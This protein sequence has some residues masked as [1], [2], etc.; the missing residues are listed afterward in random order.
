MMAVTELRGSLPGNQASTSRAGPGHVGHRRRL[1][2]RFL[3]TGFAGFAEHEVVELLLTLAIPR[4]DVKPTAKALVGRFGNLRGILDASASDLRTIE[5]IGAVA[6]VGLRII[7]EAASLYLQQTAESGPCLVDAEALASFWRSRIGA[8]R[9][10]VFE[11]AYLDS[12]YRLLRDGVEQME[13]GIPD[14]AAVYSRTVM[15]AALRRGA[16]ALIFAHNHPN[17]RAEPSEHDKALTR[18]LV[19]AADTL[20]IRVLDHLILTADGVFSFRKAGLL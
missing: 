10:E 18:T 20:Q 6:P 17:G 7:R 4:A 1:R 5:G 11:V 14:R 15:E 3:R 16:A 2:D 8:L 12:G 19:L 9:H 13:R